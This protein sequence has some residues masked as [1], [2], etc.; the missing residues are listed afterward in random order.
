[1]S[2]VAPDAP[3]APGALDALDAAAARAWLE[4]FAALVAER[5]GELTD[6]DRPIGDSDHGV[7]LH[8]GTE[9]VRAALAGPGA[10]ATT[11]GEVLAA[12]GRT[13]VSTVGGASGPL[14]GTALRRAGKALGDAP[15][16]DAA[17]LAAA[18]RAA[19]EGVVGLGGASAGDATM[20]DALEPAVVELERAAARGAGA[21]AA[22]R[23]A[24]GAAGA[25]AASTVP[26]VARKGRASYLG[27][28]SAGHLDP[29]A[30]SVELLVGALAEVLEGSA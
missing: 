24:A 28:R 10:G 1:M 29:G 23:A 7:N 26:L 14:F 16:A 9:A 19:L 20:V 25:G 2:A 22:A 27:P 21:A 6:L 13:L 12:A 15:A 3:T 8:R 5:A 30:R 17:A 4:R 18:L 11:P